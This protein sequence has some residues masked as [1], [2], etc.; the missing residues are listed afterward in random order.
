MMTIPKHNIALNDGD[1]GYPI[2]RRMVTLHPVDI[3]KT[4][5]S[6]CLSHAYVKTGFGRPP[7]AFSA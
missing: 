6:R 2:D 4:I 1:H 5:R 3:S 7:E